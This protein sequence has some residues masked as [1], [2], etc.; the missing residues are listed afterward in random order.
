MN[1]GS[2][3]P[4]RFDDDGSDDDLTISALEPDESPESRP[5]LVEA[6]ANGMRQLR[7]VWQ[8]SG[9]VALVTLFAMLAVLIGP[10]LPRLPETHPRPV[11]LSLG[12]DE[13]VARCLSGFAWSR[14]GRFIS[15][16]RSPTCSTPYVGGSAQQPNLYLFTT[17]TGKL[18]STFTLDSDVNAALGRKGFRAS[19]FAT[20][21]INY[22]ET[23]WSADGQSIAVPFFIY[24]DQAAFDGV[25]LVSVRHGASIAITSTMLASFSGFG[26][27]KGG[28]LQAATERWD[29]LTGAK[30]SISLEPSLHYHWLPTD[31]LV[32]DE[33]LS[34]NGATPP[35]GSLTPPGN[36]IGAQSFSMWRS[37]SVS[38]ENATMCGDITM[39]P[40]TSPFAALSLESIAWSPDGRY[41]LL[42]SVQTVLPSSAPTGETPAPT[43]E[44]GAPCYGGLAPGQSSITVPM[45]DAGLKSALRLLTLDPKGDNFL[46]LA[47]SPDGQ[48]LAVGATS[49]LHLSGSVV[50]YDCAT[51]AALR[52]FTGSQFSPNGATSELDVLVNPVWSPDG[53]RLLV[54]VSGPS[55]QI[56]I[57]QPQTLSQFAGL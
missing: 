46:T 37:G 20:Y 29:V 4:S 47:W 22:F 36:P 1:D 18:L 55:A 16:V 12:V 33:P 13:S 56:V 11:Y 40:T 44:D 34:P 10:H 45:H 21:S 23:D 51:G 27:P 54:T 41:L 3:L 49:F 35:A 24:G 42:V 6:L 17:S 32:A 53:S 26:A 8:A 30:S 25:V 43:P 15:A 9:V 57:I 39:R 7:G 28:V 19:D 48:Q 31:V 5:A 2:R 50:I 14:D 38:L 52:T